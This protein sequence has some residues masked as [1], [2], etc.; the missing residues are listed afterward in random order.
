MNTTLRSTQL[1]LALLLGGMLGAC[2]DSTN[3]PLFE[4]QPRVAITVFEGTQ[5]M[6]L[7]GLA[8]GGGRTRILFT[9]VTDPIPDNLPGLI[10][11]DENLRALGSPS[12]SAD[13][14]R[15]AVVA[16]VA[17]DQSE[18]VVVN[19]N[20][21][22][23]REVASVNTQ[24]IGSNPEWSSNRDKLAYTMSTKPSFGG[25][26]LFV[27]NL[28]THTVTRLTTDERLD[29]AAIRWSIDDSAIYYTRR[30]VSTA[31]VLGEW[32]TDLVRINVATGAEQVVASGIV[33]N[34]TAIS[35]AGTRVLLTRRVPTTG[36]DSTEAL[37]ES[38]VG[39]GER[40]L[41]ESGAVWARYLRDD[42]HA[43]IVQAAQ[44]GGS[45]SQY[46]VMEL[47][48]KTTTR[49][50]NVAGEAKI[51]ACVDFGPD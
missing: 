11:S 28:A 49:I 38:T 50:S 35:R 36:A 31:S 20:G 5:P 40:T 2:S 18:I 46:A 16:T 42:S 1:S 29:L 51:D 4:R 47:A 26:D 30:R 6:L 43:V 27:T 34:V 44:T 13:C 41:V 9:G 32:V 45:A 15:I 25:L 8:D 24:M 39:G 12:M 37:I 3:E 33:G 22:G 19:R 17:Y 14:S 23:G 48:S 7:S 21:S 10:P